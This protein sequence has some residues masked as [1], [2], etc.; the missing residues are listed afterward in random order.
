MVTGATGFIGSAVLG[1]L[2][3]RRDAPDGGRFPRIRVVGRRLPPEAAALVDEWVPGDLAD[4]ATLRGVCEDADVLLHLASSLDAAEDKCAAVNVRGTADL[5]GEAERAG[6]GRIVHLST[7]A[8]YGPGP[9]AGIA[10][11]EVEPAPVSSAS[12]TRLAGEA[13][14]L[15]A[16]ATV[17]RPGLV[18]GR[19]DR[20]VVPAY[21][22]LVDAVPASWEG[23]RGLHSVVAVEDL[24]RLIVHVGCLSRLPEGRVWHA[25]HP[26]P[27]ST[28]DLLSALADHRVLPAVSGEM[29]WNECVDGLRASGSGESERVFSLLTLDHW[30]DSRAVWR[31]AGCHPGPGPLA[32]LAGMASWYRSWLADHGRSQPSSAAGVSSLPRSAAGAGGPGPSSRRTLRPVPDAR[33]A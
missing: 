18:V 32:R 33:R 4:P 10:V 28:G 7:A 21:A 15:A 25:G 2:A 29:A 23:G 20:W 19:G 5:M 27:V 31:A 11:N 3:R 26:E 14:A 13:Y 1:E 12:R 17:L 30:Y 6:T 9:H 16:G 22:A 8:V 24:A